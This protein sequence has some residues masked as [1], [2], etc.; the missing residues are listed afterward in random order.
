MMHAQTH[1]YEQPP[2][3]EHT[4]RRLELEKEAGR[5]AAA[6]RWTEE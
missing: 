2:A 5:V 3:M 6:V 4:R 1:V